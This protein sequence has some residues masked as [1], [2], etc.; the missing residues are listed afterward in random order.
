MTLAD[1]W[2]AAD[3]IRGRLSS[4]EGLLVVIADEVTRTNKRGE[5]EVVVPG[6]TDKRLFCFE[7]ELSQFLKVCRR[8]GNILSEIVRRAW[9]ARDL[10]TMSKAS[11]L[12]VTGP[13]VSIVG[14]ITRDELRRELDDIG[15]NNGTGNRFIWCA[16]RRSKAAPF[17][18][19]LAD[20]VAAALTVRVTKAMIHGRKTG[21]VHL[22]DDAREVWGDVY[23]DLSEGKPGLF[24]AV[25]ARAEAHVLRL[26][27]LYAVLDLADAI[28]RHHLTAAL[29]LW[30]YTEAS[31]AYVFGDATGDQV[32]DRILA[33]L[34]ANGPMAQND[35]VDLFGRNVGSGRLGQA[36]ELLVSAGRIR[37]TREETG[38][39]PRLVWEPIS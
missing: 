28:G 8:E 27:L 34:R 38:G 39:R 19:P 10:G 14:H 12:R 11:P 37:S 9:D 3:R 17:L 24:G 31:A 21:R 29:A 16:D 23:P 30:D 4:G 20:E 18:D 25:T 15:A 2:W 7:E 5:H 36:L 6:T 26:A 33:A 32:A 22:D 13:H 1:S 35:L